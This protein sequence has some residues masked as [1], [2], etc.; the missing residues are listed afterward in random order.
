MRILITGASGMLG[1]TLV[2]KWQDKFDVFA[3][4]KDNFSENPAKI[5]TTFDLYSESYDSL[6]DWSN[7]EVIVHCAAITNVD[8][9]EKNP[10]QTLAVNAES[11]KRFL[12]SNA[13]ARLI[14]ISS[15][16]VFPDGLHLALEKDKT[17]PENVYGMSKKAGEKHIRDA[18]ENHI[19][20]RTTIVGKNI[21]RSYQGF[22]EW[23]VNSVKSGKDITLFSD[24]FF[25]P[26]TI[27]HLADEIEWLICNNF[28]GIIHIAGKE[29][30]S[31]Y[32]FGRKICAGLGLDTSLIHKESIDNVT[33]QA[34]RS[35]DQTL[36]SGYYQH[37]S[38]RSMPST[39]ETVDMIVQHF[40]KFTYA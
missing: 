27:W 33:F 40:K 17:N 13:N 34:K 10:K 19:A 35:K 24:A 39:D 25:T 1:A 38:G 14:F 36:D 12:Q 18:G 22:V 21:N 23:F 2:D 16:A 7:P 28:S 37:F 29:P 3:T 31:K 26:I 5:F 9:C 4:D 20:I 30:V 6:I 11:V 32:D 8:F 15:D